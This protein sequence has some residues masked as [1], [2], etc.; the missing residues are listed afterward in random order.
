MPRISIVTP[1]YNQG[2]YL[3]ATLR[4]VLDQGYPDL[5]YIVID[6]GSTDG[7]VDII[8]R[9]EDQ[10]AS[11]VS[12]PD[13]GQADAL[14]KGFARATGDV[15]GWLC[16]DDL[17]KPGSLWLAG[18]F[19]RLDPG[20]SM[21]YGDTEYL[22]PDGSVKWK[23]RVSWDYETLLYAFNMV[24]QPSCFFSASVYQSL[25]GLDTTLNYAMDYDLFIRMGPSAGVVH[26]PTVLSSYRLHPSSKTV[27]ERQKFERE[28]AY[29]REKALGRKLTLMDRARWYLYT[30]RVVWRFWVERGVL[31]IGYD[32]S[33]YRL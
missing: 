21:V 1:S 24:P 23:P 32:Q 9:Y 8:R 16:S 11:W 22:Y 26:V 3:E 27:S 6:G 28:W 4:S 29:T 20:L 33:K 18:A 19:F 13:E 14:A 2:E 15:F 25:G 30:A 10:L 5:E 17:L 12:E 7:S 31:K